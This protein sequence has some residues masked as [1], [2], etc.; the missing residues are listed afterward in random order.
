MKKN[1]LLIAICIVAISSCK[2][3]TAIVPPVFLGY[4]YFP[5]NIGHEL[6]YD[7]DSS[8]KDAFTGKDTSLHFQVKEIIQDTLRDLEG[9][10]T[11]RLERYKRQTTSA[12]WVIYKVWTAT[13]TDKNV[14]KDEENIT[15]VKLIFPP[16][17]NDTWNGN[18]KNNLGEELYEYISVN[19]PDVQN[20][21]VFDS[22]LTVLQSDEDDFIIEKDYKIEKY[23]IGVGMY[24]KQVHFAKYKYPQPVND[25]F[26][27]YTIYTETLISYSN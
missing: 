15:Y 6:I 9:R 4:D 1:I 2:K 7:V 17:I 16:E 12:N 5:D 19:D 3:D 24:Y 21:M 14:E 22:T 11:L 13:K 23:A 27:S 25:P 8:Y 26:E 20:N 10:L 18:S